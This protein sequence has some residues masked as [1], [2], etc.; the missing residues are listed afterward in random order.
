MTDNANGAEPSK[1]EYDVAVVGAGIMGLGTG[2]RL[3]ELGYDV[4][5]VEKDRAGMGASRAAAGMLAPTAE[6]EFWDDA[7]LKLQQQSLDRYPDFIRDVEKAS[8]VDIDYRTEGTLV[9]AR[10][11]DEDEQVER[12]FQYQKKLGLPVERLGKNAIQK[13]EPRLAP[14]TSAIYIPSDHQVDAWKLVDALLTGLDRAGGE[15]IEKNGVAGLETDAKGSVSGVTLDSGRR[16]AASAV[17]IASGAWSSKFAEVPELQAAH[18]KPVRGEALSI[19]AG[20]PPICEHVI[21]CPEVYMAPKSEGSIVIGATSEQRGFDRSVSAGG[22]LELLWEA[23]K[24]LPAIDDQPFRDVWCGFR[25]V[26]LDR[27]PLVGPSR[28]DNLWLNTG[29]G[30]HGVLLAPLSIDL[31]VKMLNSGVSDPALGDIHPKRF[32]D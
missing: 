19:D 1:S 21:R 7:P 8:G 28:L 18:I 29:H 30:R 14:A 24:L 31:S 32:L 15:L 27:M 12:I 16:I 20:D 10:D 26:T 17:V 4:L 22:V 25:P 6:I 9:V 2:W 23:W 11:R 5:V 3:A 13:C